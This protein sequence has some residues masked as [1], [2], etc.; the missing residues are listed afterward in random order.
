MSAEL[1]EDDDK[2]FL[3]STAKVSTEKKADD[4]VTV[5]QTHPRGVGGQYKRLPGGLV[6]RVD[7]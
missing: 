2:K 6:Q 4:T 5:E 7:E 3:Q 1:V